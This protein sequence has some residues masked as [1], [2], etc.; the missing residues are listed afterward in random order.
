MQKP[1]SRRE[2]RRVL[3]FAAFLMALTTL[4]YLLCA[5]AQNDQWTFGGSVL[6]VQ[7]TNT[8]LATMRLGA[9]GAWQ[10]TVFATPEP[11]TGAWFRLPYILMGKIAGLFAGPGTPALAGALVLIYHAVRIISGVVLILVTYRFVAAFLK[12]PTARFVATFL[13]SASGGLGWLLTLIGLGDWLGSQPVDFL[14]PEG[15]TFIILYSLPHLILSRILLLT[16]FILFFSARRPRILLAGLCWAG[17]GMVVPFYIAVLYV[18]FG[19]WGLAAWAQGR[20]F[21]WGLFWRAV[22]AALVPLPVLLYNAYQF[23]TNEIFAAWGAQNTLPSPHPLHYVFGYGALAVPAIWGIRWAWQRND[24]RYTLLIGWVIAAPV[25]VY[26]P[27]TVQ[28]R[29]AEGVLAPLVI[30]AVAGLRG[31]LAPRLAKRLDRTRRGAWRLAFGIVLALTLPTPALLLVGGA[32]QAINPSPPVYHP[33][34]EIAAMDWLAAH[35]PPGSVV[36]GALKTNNYLTVRADV[37]VFLGLRTETFRSAEKEAI[38][39]AFFGGTLDSVFSLYESYGIDYVFYGPNEGANTQPAP[40][41][42]S[43]L[44]TVYHKDAYTIYE[45]P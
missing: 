3:I 28:R 6:G 17:M 5:A 19:A 15:Y 18:I 32:A 11:H 34:G 14:L 42:T 2:W 20:R 4:P 43:G 45:V 25:M 13:I 44:K 29:L 38:I 30:L 41:W 39:E 33:A 37:R 36:L 12:G 9:R 21:P 26:L 1:I 10:F 8:Y 40:G 31:Y 24:A 22:T 35:A 7:D 16:G 27:V 23:T